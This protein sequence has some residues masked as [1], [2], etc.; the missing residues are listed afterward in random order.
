MAQHSSASAAAA[1]A[2]TGPLPACT[3]LSAA[4]RLRRARAAQSVQHVGVRAS[5]ESRRAEKLG[6]R[7]TDE[8]GADE[9]EVSG[10]LCHAPHRHLAAHHVHADLYEWIG[11]RQARVGARVGGWVGGNL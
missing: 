11:G 5:S 3:W 2:A 6:A 4:C 10:H 7:R 1:G 8:G 9:R